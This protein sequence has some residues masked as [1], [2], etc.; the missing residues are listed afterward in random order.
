MQVTNTEFGSLNQHWQ[1]DLG[2][3]GEV[4]DIAVSTVL[5]STW[6]SSCALLTNLFRKCFVCTSGVHILWLRRLC[7]DAVQRSSVDELAF[8]LVPGLKNLS[9]RSAAKNARVD[10]ACKADTRDV[11]GGAKDTFEVPD[12]FRAATSD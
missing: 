8:S 1:V 12:G 10:Q 9:R 11:S 6:D 7:N 5:R 2:S 3:S 4:L